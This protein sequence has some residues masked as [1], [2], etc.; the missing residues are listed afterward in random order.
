MMTMK[1]TVIVYSL[2]V[3]LLISEHTHSHRVARRMGIRM[4]IRM[5]VGT[6]MDRKKVKKI[7]NVGS[8]Y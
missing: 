7:V 6:E 8:F 3:G 5:G 1:V 4:G 2:F